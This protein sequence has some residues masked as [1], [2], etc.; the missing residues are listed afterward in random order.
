MFPRVLSFIPKITQDQ[1]LAGLKQVFRQANERGITTVFEPSVGLVAGPEEVTMMRALAATPAMT[2]RMGGALYGN[3]NDLMTWVNCYQPELLSDGDTLFTVRAMKLEGVK[4]DV[5][6]N[7]ND[8]VLNPEECLDVH[9]AL[10][11]VTIDAA[12]QCHL[13]HQIGSLLPKK[14]A[15]FVILAKNP[16]TWEAPRAAGMRDIKGL[17]TWVNGNKVFPAK[18]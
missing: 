13:D 7:G 10:R 9:Q 12:W 2:V 17:E 18:D 14:Q 4:N 1:L 15:D 11:A 3:G 6:V 8:K 16:L 5:S